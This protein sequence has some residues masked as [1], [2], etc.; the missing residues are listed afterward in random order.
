[1]AYS[2]LGEWGMELWVRDQRTGSTRRLADVPCNQMQPSWEDGSK[3]L[4]Y[5]TDCGAQS[6]AYRGGAPACRSVKREEFMMDLET[7]KNNR[8]SLAEHDA[9]F[10]ILT[11][12]RRGG[13][14]WDVDE[15]MATGEAEIETVMQQPRLDSLRP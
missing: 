10:A 12:H 14:K 1:M 8:E 9:L 5:G 6:L 4:I 3:T 7:L 15:F 13:D 11:D 2:R